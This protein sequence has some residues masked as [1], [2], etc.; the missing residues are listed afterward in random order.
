MKG[1]DCNIFPN[2]FLY[3]YYIT[4]FM[5]SNASSFFNRVTIVSMSAIAA[6]ILF[7]NIVGTNNNFLTLSQM[8]TAQ[9]LPYSSAHSHIPGLFYLPQDPFHSL[10]PIRNIEMSKFLDKAG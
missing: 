3:R 10:F 2:L 7:G 6:S 9:T 4:F 8:A 5:P 1:K